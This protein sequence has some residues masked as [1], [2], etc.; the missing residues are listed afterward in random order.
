MYVI[1]KIVFVSIRQPY[2]TEYN[3]FFLLLPDN[4]LTHVYFSSRR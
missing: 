4:A 1:P 2:K 3:S